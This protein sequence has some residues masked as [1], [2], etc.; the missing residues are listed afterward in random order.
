[1]GA[2]KVLGCLVVL[3]F[4]SYLLFQAERWRQYLVGEQPSAPAE[5]SGTLNSANSQRNVTNGS[6][7]WKDVGINFG[8]LIGTFLCYD[9][10]VTNILI[11]SLSTDAFFTR[12]P[13]LVLL[14]AMVGVLAAQTWHIL[15]SYF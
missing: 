14:V 11:V 15:P 5:N 2:T 6:I 4:S 1:M 9:V 3:T 13:L 8:M 12:P 7:W 10:M